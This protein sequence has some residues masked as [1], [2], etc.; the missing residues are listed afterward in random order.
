MK[1]GN[2]FILMTVCWNCQAA[3]RQQA[4]EHDYSNNEFQLSEIEHDYSN[5][6]FQL[7]EAEIN[8]CLSTQREIL[9]SI[10][11]N[12][13]NKTV[14]EELTARSIVVTADTLRGLTRDPRS[15]VVQV[16]LFDQ[17]NWA[18]MLREAL[19]YIVDSKNGD[20]NFTLPLKI[21]R[22]PKLYDKVISLR[23]S[24]KKVSLLDKVDFTNEEFAALYGDIT[25]VLLE[26]QAEAMNDLYFKTKPFFLRFLNTSQKAL[27][28]IWIRYHTEDVLAALR[29]SI[30][31]N[32]GSSTGK[33]SVD[34]SVSIPTPIPSLNADLGGS[35]S[36]SFA[37]SDA[38]SFA[39]FTSSK[40][41]T[42]KAG[43]TLKFPSLAKI[44]A[45]GGIE[46]VSTDIFYSLEQVMDYYSSSLLAKLDKA[47]SQDLETVKKDRKNLQQ[48]EK[49]LLILME[50]LEGL[51]QALKVLPNGVKLDWINITKSKAI[52][53]SQ[54]LKGFAEVSGNVSALASLGITLKATAGSKTYSKESSI[55]SLINEGCFSVNGIGLDATVK[56][57]GK[58]YDFSKSLPR[59][60]LLLGHLNAYIGVLTELA[61]AETDEDKK[62]LT[63][64]K[65][66][67]ETLLSPSKRIGSFGRVGVLKTCIATAIVLRELDHSDAFVPTFNQL[68]AAIDR[69]SRLE[70]FSKNKSGVR[71]AVGY[72][73]QSSQTSSVEAKTNSLHAKIY[74]SL[75]MV[76]TSFASF[77][78]TQISGSPF[79]GEDGKYISLKF[80]LPLAPAGAIG[81]KLMMGKLSSAL[82]K[83]AAQRD[84]GIDLNDFAHVTS[85]IATV[86]ETGKKKNES[87][88][89]ENKF[90]S[91]MDSYGSYGSADLA[92]NPS[93]DVDVKIYGSAQFEL[94]FRYIDPITDYANITPLPGLEVV[95]NEKGK[96]VMDYATVSNLLN[97]G[98]SATTDL[99]ISSSAK[100]VEKGLGKIG[101]G[102]TLHNA[103]ASVNSSAASKLSNLGKN[104]TVSKLIDLGKVSASLPI[105]N[106][107]VASSVGKI[108]KK[109]GP[110]TLH[111][112]IAKSNA[113]MLGLED[114][115]SGLNTAYDSLK[116]AQLEQLR[117]I[118]RNINRL[119]SNAIFELQTIYNE[120]M[121][122]I[123][124]GKEK[125]QCNKVFKKFLDACKSLEEPLTV[126]EENTGGSEFADLSSP[127]AD[128]GDAIVGDNA[129]KS[130]LEA[131][132]AVVRMNYNY[133]FKP[134]Y[135]SAYAV[136]KASR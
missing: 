96:W 8:P 6:E 89:Q 30:E 100:S 64:K 59:P 73:A 108:L 58:E 72:G 45:A 33:Q 37:G 63:K 56:I 92:E 81:A 34:V 95:K 130:A 111:D 27:G 47:H 76:E 80:S 71:K 51:L 17:F 44:S 16:D 40:S 120:I 57:I 48:K 25:N 12:T 106:V 127:K 77:E 65:R 107:A 7:S 39:F 60:G 36:E 15:A 134:Y 91:G 11:P 118:F 88:I 69:L 125:D 126:A 24:L 90:H 1:I 82:Q 79:K 101:P 104:S 68:Y 32:L 13:R 46:K 10:Q 26:V 114:N 78:R 133:S 85:S 66:D 9:A 52:D 97:S 18:I 109:T 115:K 105:L 93:E 84:I 61:N 43:V 49:E 22:T 123:T 50:E 110:D 5:N 124:S 75:P 112:I 74:V 129:M 128:S 131:F 98:I 29:A 132:D 28:I 23:D 21:S 119:D 102:G 70:E 38:S 2:A 3:S 116:S 20:D 62:N 94:M 87:L 99:G 121:R 55:M 86:K 41:K 103:I 83:A 19:D 135:D 35:S 122:N 4:I 53:R 113:L 42:G 136:G 31:R 54:E 14:L 117:K 67:Y